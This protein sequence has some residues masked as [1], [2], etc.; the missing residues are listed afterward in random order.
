MLLGLIFVLG[1]AM[2][3]IGLAVVT[4]VLGGIDD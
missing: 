2:L 1:S 3:I 4:L